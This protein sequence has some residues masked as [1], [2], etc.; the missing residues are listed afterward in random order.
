MRE[1]IDCFLPCSDF[2]GIQATISQ[3]MGNKTIQHIHLLVG[4]DFDS[5]VVPEDIDII[6]SDKPF[7]TDTLREIAAHTDA[8]YVL[9][10]TKA[11]PVVL[12]KNALERMLRVAVDSDATMVYGDHY[13][14]LDG[15]IAKHPCIDYHKGSIRDDF[16]FGQLLLLPS[17]L[18]HEYVSTAIKEDFDYAGLYALRL[19]LSRKGEIFHL[20][21]YL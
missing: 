11:S 21:E 10:S 12:G 13:D 1:K 15:N 6:T 4:S 16:D 3:L 2:E 5:C 18:L 9:F 14:T 20:A 17:L 8:D 7:S 19:F